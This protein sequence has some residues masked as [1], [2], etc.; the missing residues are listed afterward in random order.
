M[1]GLWVRAET[2]AHE[3]RTPLL[4]RQA[5]ALV[6]RGHP[7]VVERSSMRVVGDSDYEAVGCRLVPPGAWTEAPEDY[8][9][10]G[11]KE[12]P[13]ADFPLRHRHIYFAHCY[14][15]QQHSEQVLNRFVA[16]GGTLLDMEYL[17]D[18][19]GVAVIVKELDRLSGY[20]GAA[21]ALGFFFQ[22][23]AG[24]APS[25]GR[26]YYPDRTSLLADIG[27]AA[28]AVGRHPSVVVIGYRGNAGRGATQLCREASIDPVLWG[29][30]ETGA[31]GVLATLNRFE[32][33]VHCIGTDQAGP[34]FLT[35]DDLHVGSRVSV[36]A[37]VTCDVGSPVHR[38]P[39][40]SQITTFDDPVL[41]VGPAA[42]PVHVIAIDHLTTWLPY[43]ASAAIAEPLVVQL[44]ALLAGGPDRWPG[45][46]RRTLDL[47]A[48]GSAHLR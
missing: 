22:K 17:T 1:A 27:A 28:R 39:F 34:P 10:L 21:M 9:I 2:K 38:Y 46:W 15:G 16:G 3:R 7:V 19:G 45:P 37:D 8:F 6:A 5:A 44:Q 24:G 4:P 12:L 25:L 35:A 11:I 29:R 36:L 42:A 33:V 32:V 18:S 26:P 31:P 47:F 43:E 23:A 41:V 14:K 48:E 30:A 40:Y 20:V 13:P